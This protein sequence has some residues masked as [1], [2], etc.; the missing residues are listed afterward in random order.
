MSE[1]TRKEIDTKLQFK[2]KVSDKLV[3]NVKL[4]HWNTL[5][6]RLATKDKYPAATAAH[7]NWDYRFKLIKAHVTKEDPDV[8]GIC[9]IDCE[10]NK[11]K[12]GKVEVAEGQKAFKQMTDWFTQKGY[13]WHYAENETG[14]HGTAVFY[15]KAKLVLT[16]WETQKFD[17]SEPYFFLACK[18]S[19]AV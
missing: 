10:K 15:K 4:M 3:L 5:A 1:Y 12:F 14:C 9:E 13:L 17:P 6:Q 2:K 18:F 11:G 8:L 7:L 19:E 16:K